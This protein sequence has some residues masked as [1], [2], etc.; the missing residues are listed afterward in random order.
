[1]GYFSF[2]LFFSKMKNPPN[3]SKTNFQK[4]KCTYV[5]SINLK[6]KVT[7]DTKNIVAALIYFCNYPYGTPCIY[8]S[9]L[10]LDT[11]Y[12][13]DQSRHSFFGSFIT[14]SD[15]IPLAVNFSTISLDDFVQKFSTYWWTT[16]K[17]ANTYHYQNSNGLYF[18]QFAIQ[19]YIF[20][21]LF[22][23]VE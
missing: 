9:A 14:S 17:T 18:H 13:I 23:D 2:F 12:V 3:H 8:L 22:N 10:Y 5:S 16:T 21:S 4:S 7:D 6:G 11:Y 19:H 20:S 15:T 1:M